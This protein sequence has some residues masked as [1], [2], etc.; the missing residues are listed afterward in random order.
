MNPLDAHTPHELFGEATNDAAALKRAY[1]RLIRTHGPETDPEA[2]R[3]IRALYEQAV[4]DLA[5]PKVEAPASSS[6]SPIE[7]F[8]ARLVL[9]LREAPLA[10]WHH[11]EEHQAEVRQQSPQAWLALTV[12]TLRGAGPYQTEDVLDH[13]IDRFQSA[14]LALPDGVADGLTEATC[15]AIALGRCRADAPTF[16]RVMAI[17]EVPRNERMLILAQERPL[18]EALATTHPGVY[19]VMRGSIEACTGRSAALWG[20]GPFPDP[21]ALPEVDAAITAE[22][23]AEEAHTHTKKARTTQQTLFVAV[24]TL[25]ASPVMLV[26]LLLHGEAAE[27][28]EYDSAGFFLLCVFGVSMVAARQFLPVP[29]YK[30]DL[31]PLKAA[32]SAVCRRR[33]LWIH[34]L[35]G[36]PP[37]PRLRDGLDALLVDPLSDLDV[38]TTAHVLSESPS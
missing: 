25:I 14:D 17:L 21:G 36:A 34:Q 8:E 27:R 11:W 3:H 6:V 12:A 13:W 1:A 38:V 7:G 33:G 4:A 22:L 10:A 23:V 28:S 2:F 35:L 20:S 31:Q 5:A 9:L 19:A 32:I 26:P 15:D 37:S 29:T 24:A 16:I 30:A 18:I